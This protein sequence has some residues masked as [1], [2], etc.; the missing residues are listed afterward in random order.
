MKKSAKFKGLLIILSG[1]SGSGKSTLLNRLVA[2]Q[3]FKKSLFKSIS[4]TT[5]PQ[6]SGEKDKKDYF[7][8]SQ[9][10]FRRFNSEKKIL[11]W[12]RYLGYYYGTPR[13]FLEA[14]LKKGNDI[15]MCLDLK[16]ALKLK[17]I[18][19]ENTLTIFILP[20]SIGELGARIRRR[21][22]KTCASEIKKRLSLAK[23]ELEAA[24][25]YDYCLANKEIDKATSKLK[26]I[27]LKEKLLR[28]K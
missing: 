22:L 27:I 23:K 26:G 3:F 7:F 6:R 28:N 4:Y 21:C 18:Y 11:E 17:K 20:P 12:T 2:D 9:R 10:E 24:Q 13:G 5:R 16:G 14:Q 19:P 1:P 15:I 8:L 25:E